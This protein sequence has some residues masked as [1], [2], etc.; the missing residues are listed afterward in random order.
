MQWIQ[1]MIWGAATLWAAQKPGR[2]RNWGFVLCAFLCLS[3]GTQLFLLWQVG[4][5]SLETA[6]PL[7]LC[8]MMAILS[9][10]MILLRSQ[11]LFQFSMLLG[12]PAAFLA[13]CFPAIAECAHPLLMAASFFRLHVLI[14][15]T[16]LLLLR[17]GFPLPVN[18]RPVFLSANIYLLLVAV[19]NRL[20]HTNYL[21]LSRAPIGTPLAYLAAYGSATYLLSLEMATMLVVSGLAG[22]YALLPKWRQK[23]RTGHRKDRPLLGR[24]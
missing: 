16:P 8:S 15:C 3:M 14:L 1:L 6:V 21:F 18:P 19:F 24:S 2:A 4:Q 9:I 10:P 5:L 23:R 12:A 11:V 22:L 17:Q 7:H 13:L 20:F